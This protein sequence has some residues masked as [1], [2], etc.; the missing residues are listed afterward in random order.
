LSQKALF[1]YPK[2]IDA[3]ELA[4]AKHR[5]TREESDIRSAEQAIREMR[6]LLA[7]L[8]VE[9]TPES[10][11]VIVDGEEQPASPEGRWTIELGPGQHRIA[12]RAEGYAPAEETVTVVSGQRDR[13]VELA[14]TPDKGLV[15]VEAGDPQVAISIDQ[16]VLGYGRW[17]GYLAPGTH[18]VQMI[19]PKGGMFSTQ[20]VVAAG[21]P[22]EVRPGPG[23]VPALP[24]STQPV[25]P[26]P[27][28]PPPRPAPLAQPQRG[29]YL[30]GAGSLLW[31]LGKPAEF[32]P[33]SVNSGG[34]GALRAGYRVNDIAGFDLMMQYM[35]ISIE[36]ADDLPDL[37]Q[38]PRY[39]FEA[40][41]LG[42]NLR[43]MSP[44]DL[45]RV[46]G[47][48]GG[49]LSYDS[50]RFNADDGLICDTCIDA[51]GIDPFVFVDLGV[52]IDLG[53][54]VV[55]FALEGYFQS[56][57][58][59]DAGLDDDT[60]VYSPRALIHLGGSLRVGYAF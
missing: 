35:N 15:T 53:G 2:A 49:G 39:T 24:S 25:L 22:Q 52:E 48:V 20:I 41:R 7:L 14:L 36:A 21:K 8:V 32:P 31:P 47:S 18:L 30:L 9:V 46:T 58:G 51:A 37:P 19:A 5:D 59:I 38:R 56:A 40:G 17:S 11:T 34:A 45:L 60:D 43:L 16:Q 27:P 28:P 4:L 54:P 13:R 50:I 57:R 55:G 42:L 33:I 44:G 1:R 10:A 23:G 3:L 26:P 29:V 6:A 12:A